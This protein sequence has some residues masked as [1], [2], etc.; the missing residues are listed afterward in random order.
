MGFLFTFILS[1]L[2]GS[3]AFAGMEGNVCTDCAVRKCWQT[4]DKNSKSIFS[5]L[6]VQ[7]CKQTTDLKNC[8]AIPDSDERKLCHPSQFCQDNSNDE[9]EILRQCGLGLTNPTVQSLKSLVESPLNFFLGIVEAAATCST[10]ENCGMYRMSHQQKKEFEINI[11]AY[12]AKVYDEER[13]EEAKLCQQMHKGYGCPLPELSC[14]E[15]DRFLVGP[16]KSQIVSSKD[17]FNKGRFCAEVAQRVGKELAD[18]RKTHAKAA[19]QALEFWFTSYKQRFP[20]YQNKYVLVEACKL[21]GTG[22]LF[23]LF[24]L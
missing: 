15:W 13:A 21:L 8:E 16:K 1:S 9:L 20:C 24:L 18:K 12:F 3:F 6:Q 7:S 10:I 11:K 4:L 22:G 23:T 17:G 19:A 2:L 14:R 5:D